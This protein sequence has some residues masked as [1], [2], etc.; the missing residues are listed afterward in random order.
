MLGVLSTPFSD[1]VWVYANNF[2]NI[3][4]A[5]TC[6]SKSDC[7]MPKLLLYF[8]F[9]FACICFFH[10]C[11]YTTFKTDLKERLNPILLPG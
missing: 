9:Q 3:S 10:A 6:F 1:C 2:S 7:L 4:I 5:H 8:C 11:L